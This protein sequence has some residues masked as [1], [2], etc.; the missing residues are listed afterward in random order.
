MQ[1]LNERLDMTDIK[2]GIVKSQEFQLLLRCIWLSY[3]ANLRN[4]GKDVYLGTVRYDIATY[5]KHWEALPSVL[6]REQSVVVT[7]GAKNKDK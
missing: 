7:V 3:M 6:N 4:S 1:E 2:D 5:S